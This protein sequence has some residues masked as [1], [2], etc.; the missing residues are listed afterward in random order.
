MNTVSMR[1]Y[2]LACVTEQMIQ[3]NWE[4]TYRARAPRPFRRSRTAT[5]GSRAVG[6]PDDLS[7]PVDAAEAWK[8]VG[9]DNDWVRHAETKAAATLATAGVIGGVLYNLVKDQTTF[10]AI[11][12]IFG[13][14]CG[15]LAFISAICAVVALWPRL[16]ASEPPTSALYFDHIARRY[17]RSTDSAAY[18]ADLRA[19]TASY[20]HLRA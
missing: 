17:P 2:W 19:L 18:I 4:T 13:P 12:K 11:L 6:P 5:P 20:T 7:A 10:G 1:P 16:R 15:G 14:L 3:A 9:L 8:A